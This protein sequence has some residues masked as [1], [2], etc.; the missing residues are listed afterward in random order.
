ME[1][2]LAIGTTVLSGFNTVLSGFNT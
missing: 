2:G 1:R